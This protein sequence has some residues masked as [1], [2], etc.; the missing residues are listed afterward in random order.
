MYIFNGGSKTDQRRKEKKKIKLRKNVQTTHTL[1]FLDW[2]FFKTTNLEQNKT[3]IR[4]ETSSIW[5][6]SKYNWR[7]GNGMWN[8]SLEK[9]Y[10]LGNLL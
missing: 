4:I 1:L 3:N 5:G 10:Y 8:F 9:R 6:I 2:S 7:S